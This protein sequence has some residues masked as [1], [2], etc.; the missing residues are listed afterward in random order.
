[1]N[2]IQ[3][4]EKIFSSETG[5]S[6][7]NFINLVSNENLKKYLDVINLDFTR[8]FYLHRKALEKGNINYPSASA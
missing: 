7:E 4:L 2:H 6:K 5:I 1:L 8:L 3:L